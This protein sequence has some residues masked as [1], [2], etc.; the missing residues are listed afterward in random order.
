MW[1]VLMKRI[2]FLLQA[3]KIER[4]IDREVKFHLDMEARDRAESGMPV[5]QARRSARVDFGN[6][7]GCKEDVRD[8]V[9]LRLWMD[10]KRDLIYAFRAMRREPGFT[11]IAVVTLALGIGATTSIFSVVDGVLLRRVPVADVERVMMIWE[12]D[13]QSNTTREP[14]S[15]PDYLDFGS[16][17]TNFNAIAAIAG[18]EVNLN[19][20]SGDPMRVAA[21]AMT[22]GFLPM[23]G[24]K[25]LVGRDFNEAEDRAGGSRAVMISEALWERSFGRDPAVIGQ[26]LRLNDIPRAIVGVVQQSADFVLLQLIC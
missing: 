17:V 10:S 11:L 18:T 22:R 1:R 9:G 2:R 15:V 19:P 8:A 23:L 16:R 25:P 26:L 4:D 12:T 3:R 20:A 13:R 21:L 24:I 7:A 6:V 5:E 14:A